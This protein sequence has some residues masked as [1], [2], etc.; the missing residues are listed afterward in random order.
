MRVTLTSRIFSPEPAAASF[1]LAALADALDIDGHAVTVLTSTV[2]GNQAPTTRPTVTVKRRPVLRD[3]DGYVRGYLQ[4]LS[5]DLP[6]FFRLLVSKADV[7]V[8]EPPP[9]TGFVVRVACA[10]RRIPYVYYAADIWSDAAVTTGA[11][12]WVVSVVRTMELA[13]L[14]GASRILSVSDGVTRRLGE[15]GLSRG[16][17]TIGNG[18]D[19]DQF[20]SDGPGR[21][22]HAPFLL[23]AGTASEWHG[24]GIFVDAF[25]QVRKSVPDATLVFLGQGAEREQLER[26]SAP[27]GDGAVRFE[28]RLPPAE[29]AAWLRG[30]ASSL[31][32]VRPGQGYDFAFPTKMYASAACGTP[33]IYAGRG[34][35]R[36]FASTP[37]LGLAVDYSVD[38]V[39]AAMT[40]ALLH[41]PTA[42]RRQ[43]IAA[44]AR[45]NVALGAIA[46][47]A[48]RVVAEASMSLR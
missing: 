17:V 46:A 45:D 3:S 35:G 42:Q 10:I 13:A 18:I 16:V 4:Y 24:A 20:A 19:T 32:S 8:T 40:T 11:P 30:A 25:A 15:L 31:A 39:A 6:L 38:E 37:D 48:A 41:P 7:V 27:L 47:R 14:R 12:R 26:A 5:F 33:V 21:T 29:V 2:P 36:A 44:W 9:T 22:D 43:R 28:P 34:P 23:Y 1:R